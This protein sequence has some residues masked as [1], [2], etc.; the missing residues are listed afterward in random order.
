MGSNKILIFR[1]EDS[2]KPVGGPTG[3]LYN[4]KKG[5]D[6]Y[7]IDN[8]HFIKNKSTKLPHKRT[9]RNTITSILNKNSNAK[10]ENF[11]LIMSI[12][13]KH[14]DP[15]KDFSE[16]S[17]V[18][19]HSTIHLYRNRGNLDNYN[20]KVLLT[21]HSPK[22]LHLEILEDQITKSEQIIYNMFKSKL[23]IID[24]Y[25]FERA[26]HI[27][28]PC[29][30]AEEPYS[31][32]WPRY[33]EIKEKRQHS[34]VYVPTGIEE[35]IPKMSRED[36]LK[37]YSI[38][39]DSFVISYVGRH[40]E[41]KGY[42]LLKKIGR[43]VLGNYNNVYFLI[44]G[45]EEPL[46]GLSHERWIEAGWTNDPHS[47]IAAAD[48]FILPNKETYFDLIMLEVLSLGKTVLCSNTGG[49]KYFKAFN[50]KSI[51][52]FD[53]QDEAVSQIEKVLSLGIDPR[54]ELA[55]LNYDLFKNNFTTKHFLDKY[56][57]VLDQI[58]ED[59]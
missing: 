48:L 57:N 22:P 7:G 39:S 6:F 17:A 14:K 37:K 18:H 51:I 1:D 49:N 44:A 50:K 58:L 5:I 55:K 21:S 8:I 47:H 23:E 59:N 46:K 42:D 34:F 31:N 16:Y 25:S 27:I 35:C 56:I 33:K 26:D 11:K 10:L 4:L 19:F 45:K 53:N 28:F 32:N 9:L 13:N 54:N 36:I 30:D 12:V 3:Y 40:N 43:E 38:P 2:L 15:Y 24:K 52:Y 29:E 20:G 41:T